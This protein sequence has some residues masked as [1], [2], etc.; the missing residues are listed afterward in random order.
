[1]MRCLNRFGRRSQSMVAH[2]ILGVDAFSA[3]L[4]IRGAMR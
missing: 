2:V 1:M 4:L 3:K